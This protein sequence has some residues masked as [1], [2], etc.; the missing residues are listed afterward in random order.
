MVIDQKNIFTEKEKKDISELLF[1]SLYE[2]IL[3]VLGGKDKAILLFE[4]SYLPKNCFFI[5][6]KDT[7]V[8]FLAFKTR[9]SAFFN[10]SILEFK[11][12][13]G[14]FGYVKA[15]IFHC[16]EHKIK[17]EEIH[18]EAIAVS[19]SLRGR[20]VGSDLLNHFFIY[21]KTN[22]FKIVSLE[23]VDTNEK[24]A[25][26]Y[27]KLG[28]KMIKK[29]SMRFLKLFFPFTFDYVFLMKKRLSE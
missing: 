12:I 10:P 9:G 3:P 13:Y 21:A 23:V 27:K 6:E 20:G 5:K 2:K 15:V 25:L 26:L 11:K 28:F 14:I 1:S 4:N 24:A 29:T 16:I 19:A 18:I 8:G 7:V 22:D 17:N